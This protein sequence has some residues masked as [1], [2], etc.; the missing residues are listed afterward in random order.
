M[1]EIACY[2]N[3]TIYY[4]FARKRFTVFAVVTSFQIKALVSTLNIVIYVLHNILSGHLQWA[5]W[6]NSSAD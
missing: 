2:K 6:N 4:N 5:T 1:H 3:L